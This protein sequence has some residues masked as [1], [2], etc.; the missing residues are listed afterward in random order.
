MVGDDMNCITKSNLFIDNNWQKMQWNLA[1]K[2]TFKFKLGWRSLLEV[3]MSKATLKFL[4]TTLIPLHLEKSSSC[5][6]VIYQKFN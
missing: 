4:C 2:L 5:K 6:G 1:P 3:H